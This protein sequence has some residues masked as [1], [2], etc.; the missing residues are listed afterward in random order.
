MT[1]FELRNY[2]ACI[3]YLER[4]L[5]DLPRP[6]VGALREETE[7]LLARANAYTARVHLDVRPVAALVTADGTRVDGTLL[8][9]PLG[10]HELEFR[11]DNHVSE[12]R[13]LLVTGGESTSLSVRL[14]PVVAAR[15]PAPPA[16]E[17]S[18]YRNP[19]LWTAVGAVV[20]GAVVGMAVAFTRDRTSETAEPVYRG[21]SG[22]RPVVAP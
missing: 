13:K 21:S 5:T 16:R 12:K 7:K 10:E 8:I 2:P 17:R 20:A 15:G 1:E 6:L 9:L 18:L 22:A 19:W 11:G 3:R 4:A 14:V